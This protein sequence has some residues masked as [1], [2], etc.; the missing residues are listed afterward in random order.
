LILLYFKKN[1]F[2]TFIPPIQQLHVLFAPVWREDFA[3]TTKSPLS[4]GAWFTVALH[5]GNLLDEVFPRGTRIRGQ[6]QHQ[7]PGHQI[8][9]S[10]RAERQGLKQQRTKHISIRH[11]FVTDR[12]EKGDLTIAWCPTA[13]MIGDY[14]K[15]SSRRV[16]SQVSGLHNGRSSTYR[17]FGAPRCTTPQEY[18]GENWQRMT[19]V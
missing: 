9:N 11:F 1:L 7:L 5:A 15:T 4:F 18:I 2:R 3:S 16:F 19:I 13:A 8:R 14:A 12:V 10:F 6:R 17:S